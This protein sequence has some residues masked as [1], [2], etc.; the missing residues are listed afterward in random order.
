MKGWNSKPEFLHEDKTHESEKK[1][2]K[3]FFDIP[4]LHGENAI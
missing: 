3:F 1:R 4:A 2:L